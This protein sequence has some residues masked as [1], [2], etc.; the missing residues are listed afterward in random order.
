[1]SEDPIEIQDNPLQLTIP[2]QKRM[3]DIPPEKNKNPGAPPPGE[4]CAWY[5]C[6][7]YC[8]LAMLGCSESYT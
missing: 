6:C 5:C 3:D 7:C 1:M 4:E 8:I 2:V